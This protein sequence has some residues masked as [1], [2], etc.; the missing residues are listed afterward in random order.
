MKTSLFFALVLVGC[1]SRPYSTLSRADFN[2]V[3]VR[4]N[5][6][7]YWTA[8]RDRDGALDPDEVAAL[9]FYPTEGRWVE[10]GAFTAELD[11]VYTR[12]V[13]ASR[14]R[15]PG[16]FPPDEQKRR[17]AVVRE[18]DQGRATLVATKLAPGEEAF[19]DHMLTVARLVDELYDRTTGAEALRARVPADDPASQSAFRRNR[20]PRCVAA[21][22]EKDPACTAIP[23]APKPKVDIYPA[24]LQDDPNF[25][26]SL[27]KQPNAKELMAPFTVVRKQ[28]AALEAIPYSVA[29]ADPMKKIA[30]EL[31]AAAGTLDASA[32]APLVAYL[33]AA[34]T[35]FETDD[36]QPADEA[37]AKM[38]AENSKW[39]VRVAPDE[40]YWEPC[41]L[42]AGF[43]LTFARIN[44]GSLAWQRKLV[45]VQADMEKAIA[46]AAGPPYAARPVSFH[47]P[48]F[49]DIVVN[50]GDDRDPLGGTIGQSLPNWGP[51]ANEGRGRTVAMS[52][53]GDDPDSQATRTEQARS[54]LDAESA[55]AYAEGASEP[56]LLSTILHEA[57]HNL[58]P[59]HE[60]QVGGK[61]DDVV[62]G[63]PMASML[64]ELK[65]QSGALFLIEMLRS[66]G[67]ISDELAAQTYVDSIVW[68]FGHISQGM[69]TATGGRKAYSQL[70]AIQIGYLMDN[71]A[72]TWDPNATAANGKDKGAFHLHRDKLVRVVAEM[73]KLTGGIKARGDKA[74]AEALAAKYVDGEVVPHAIIVERWGRHPR[75]SYVYS[76]SR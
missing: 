60:Y 13:E 34:A 24:D 30:A 39:Y 28:G 5:L 49:I 71:G 4:E 1:A 23:G 21:A 9:L 59:S 75:A 47:L 76:I 20:G 11:A 22:T 26:S 36:W 42:K 48:D 2:R 63:G 8:D 68:A 70:A 52:N 58:G 56:G 62:F 43:H 74:A 14:R 66:R 7:V 15:G 65:A 45:P 69:Y 3:A 38:N 37:W 54:I 17:E 25:C 31:R 44:Q 29:Y 50:A 18:L 16:N 57:T 32:E 55:L 33:G 40:T 46:E 53:L 41:A 67:L 35:S 6:P 12:L 61:T 72:L 51:V 10:G 64:E 73:M 19:V 27:E